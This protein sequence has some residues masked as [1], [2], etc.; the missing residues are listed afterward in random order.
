MSRWNELKELSRTRL[1]LLFRQPGSL[2]WMLAFPALLAAVLGLAFRAGGPEPSKIGIVAGPGAEALHARLAAGEHL[3]L[4]ILDADT[5]RR[6]LRRAA[7]DVLVTPA[8]QPSDLPGLVLDPDRS[9]AD[10]ARVRLLLALGQPP[11]ALPITTV[12]EPGARYIDFLFPGLMGHNLLGG[13]MW[14]I[15]HAVVELRQKK[16]LKRMLVTPMRRASFLL[17]FLIERVVFLVIEISLLLGFGTLVLGVPFRA[18][19]LWFALLCLLGTAAFSGLSMLIAARARTA[20]T[21]TGLLNLVS[22]PMWLLSGVFFSYE[23]FPEAIHPF[24]R[25]LPLTAFNDGLRALMIDG[26]GLLGI[27][28]EIAIL[29]AWSVGGFLVALVTFRWE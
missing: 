26:T 15:A 19:P 29:T 4:E 14:L 12:K 16:L 8:S 20:E 7:I 23:R 2:F 17:S 11:P 21:A 5:A 18:N 27:G 13:C 28:T 3:D 22:M 25:A 10:T 9:E 24:L 6:K 1:L